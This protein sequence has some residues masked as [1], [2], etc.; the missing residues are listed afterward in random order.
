MKSPQELLSQD[1]L[2]STRKSWREV[3]ITGI[4]RIDFLQRLSSQNLKPKGKSELGEEVPA[5]K[6]LPAAFLNAN[7][8]VVSLF[9]LFLEEDRVRLVCVPDFLEPTLAFLD[10]FHFG[11]D[12]AWTVASEPVA[13]PAAMPAEIL[14][15]RDGHWRT[16]VVGQKT[17]QPPGQNPNFGVPVEEW[18]MDALKA[19]V[20]IPSHPREFGN[21]NIILEAPLDE[22]VHRNKGCYPGQ[23]VIERIFTYGNVAKRTV[24][25][26]LGLP[27][28]STDGKGG[29]L[30][31]K[32]SEWLGAEI[33]VAGSD[34]QNSKVGEL[35]SIYEWPGNAPFGLASVKRLA[36]ESPSTKKF[37]LVSR[38]AE[39]VT[40]RLI[41]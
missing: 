4:D 17:G 7:G 5:E 14:C 20:G 3:V 31:L 32:T 40:V 19:F 9:H 23:E 28:N 15:Q 1:R 39:V 24:P 36:L 13:P 25:L 10:K 8:S 12:I 33:R 18:Q 22:Y 16:E 35:L 2:F 37:E 11:E 41:S 38:E 6:F 21:S 30:S 27:P 29:A 34:G 26:E